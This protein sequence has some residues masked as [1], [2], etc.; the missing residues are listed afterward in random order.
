MTHPII[1]WEKETPVPENYYF[2]AYLNARNGRLHFEDLDLA[3]LFLGDGPDQGLGRTLP[4]PLEIIYL[5][6]IRHR[7]D[8]MR[9]IFADVIAEVGYDGRFHYTYASKANAAEEVIRTTLGAGTHH[10]MSS[11][12]DIDIAQHMIRRGLLTPDR[13]I[14][15]NGFKPAGSDYA[16]NILRLKRDHDQLIPV[17]EDLSEISP[18]L[19]S[20]LSF[21]VGLRQKSYG[22]NTTEAEIEAAN[23]RFGLNL[24]ALWKAADYIAA[25]PNLNLVL[26]H[27]MV[28]SQITNG[29]EFLSYLKPGIELYARLRQHTPTLRIF[30]FGGGMPVPMTLNFE[31]DYYGFVRQLLTTMQDVCGR[32]NVPVPDIMGEF[33]RYTTSEHG[34]HLF[35][36]ITAK[37]NQSKYPWYIMDG[38]IMSSFPDSW[39]LSEHFIVLPLTNLD[40]P[41]QRVQLGGITCDS[42]DVYPPKPSHSPLYLP[43]DTDNLYIGFFS[44]GA[45]QEMLGGVRG[46][47]HCVL[48]EANELIVDREGENG[49][50]KFQLLAGQSAGDV[51]RNLGYHI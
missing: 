43:V 35:K 18:L 6:V 49:R 28:G 19:E 24:E 15:C 17:I 27:Y 11:T 21:D 32:Y 9:H 3:Q 4:S 26:Y 51:L 47:K 42:D 7:I 5:P 12:V 30:D 14:I 37:E 39:A 25:A 22:H 31:F 29:D 23:S 36:I 50:Y 45:Y 38:S 34:A 46:S 20:G 48:P 8:Q 16:A 40:K 1:G 10:E 13:M 41:F 2:N 44:I 33:G